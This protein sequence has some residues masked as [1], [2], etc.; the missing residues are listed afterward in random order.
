[1]H[2]HRHGHP[3]TCFIIPSDML[4]K[5]AAKSAN[6]TE[7]QLLLDQVEHSAQLR[8]ERIGAS[9]AS[10][11]AG[12]PTGE[13]RRTVYD[14]KHKT[15]LPGKLVRGETGG[16]AKD[17]AINEAFDGAGITYDFYF[18][19]LKRNS[20]DGRG[21]RLDSSVHYDRDF[22]NAFWNGRQMTY[23]DGDG[24]LFTGF[25]RAIDVIA[26]ELTHGVTQ[27]TVPG[28]G[29]VYDGQS[30]ALNES[31]SDV[32]GSVVKQWSLKQGSREADWLIGAGIMTPAVGKA[33]RSMKEPGNT[34]LTWSGDDQ[35]GTMAGYVPGG[36]VHTNSGIPNHAFYLAAIK[37]NAHS[38][39]KAAPIWY[40]AMSLLHPEATFAEAATATVQAA[41]L[42]FGAGS[43]EAKA[44]Q[45]AWREVGVS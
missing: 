34:A 24:K 10:A 45:A 40:K 21:M 2:M 23:G 35:P 33:L 29:L 27:F 6:D 3:C 42:L 44:V 28:G 5:L 32:F 38:W 1:M 39:E 17:A 12:L 22:N 14:A 7:R 41:E 43:A 9:L 37:L 15:R 25:T 18:Q 4:R 36:D 31:M 16:V 30:G 26:H 20:I 8:G 11:P 13:K 19:V